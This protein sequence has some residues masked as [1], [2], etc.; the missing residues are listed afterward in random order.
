MTVPL[1]TH[2]LPPEPAVD[3]DIRLAVEALIVHIRDTVG[4]GAALA[5]A[6]ALLE[7]ARVVVEAVR[8]GIIA[9]IRAEQHTPADWA[10]DKA[11]DRATDE[12][13]DRVRDIAVA[14]QV[15]NLSRTGAPVEGDADADVTPGHVCDSGDF[16]RT[17][18]PPPCGCM[19]TF[20][21]VC[22]DRQDPCAHDHD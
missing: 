2:D 5:L 21:T 6:P 13:D 1:P 15:D 16:D 22:G 9:R 18:C 3:E 14:G 17:E 20:C 4:G 11:E 8:P 10:E 19:H 12:A 7:E